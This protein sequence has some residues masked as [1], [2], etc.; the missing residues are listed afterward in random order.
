MRVDGRCSLSTLTFASKNWA[1][2]SVHLQASEGGAHGQTPK[3]VLIPSSLPTTPWQ[4]ARSAATGSG[5][6]WQSC[7]MEEQLDTYA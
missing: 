6:L 1:K 5:R 4:L 2:L 3:R 7:S